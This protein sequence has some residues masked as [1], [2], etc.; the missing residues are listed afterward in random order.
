[1]SSCL[2]HNMNEIALFS[3]LLRAI[4]R[5]WWEGHI[6]CAASY[7][8]RTTADVSFAGSSTVHIAHKNREFVPCFKYFAVPSNSLFFQGETTTKNEKKTEPALLDE[9]PLFMA[10]G[11]RNILA[12]TC[13]WRFKP[14]ASSLLLGFVVMYGVLCVF[15]LNPTMLVNGKCFMISL[16]LHQF[17]HICHNYV[18]AF[19]WGTLIATQLIPKTT[20]FAIN[21]WWNSR[22]LH[23]LLKAH[24]T[25]FGCPLTLASTAQRAHRAQSSPISTRRMWVAE[26]PS[27]FE[28][29]TGWWF[30]ILW[31]FYHI[32]IYFYGDQVKT[33]VHM[34]YVY[35]FYVLDPRQNWNH[36]I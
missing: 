35:I 15:I 14:W 3:S 32:I 24:W 34:I 19:D 30:Y 27:R 25:A 1:M 31:K 29:K 22:I 13:M 36:H 5:S 28:T 6:W 26:M 4:M 7:G 2:G 8:L 20:V 18:F 11:S 9:D 17:L 12:R 23:V 16:F 33:T 21:N 10:W